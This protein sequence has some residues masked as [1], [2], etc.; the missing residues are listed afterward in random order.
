[1]LSVI[2]NGYHKL[3]TTRSWDFVGLPLTSRRDL[4][5]ESDIVVGVF[6]TGLT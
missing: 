1:M 5:K 3:H 4:K 6:D 2:P